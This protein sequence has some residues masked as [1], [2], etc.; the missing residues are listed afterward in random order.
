MQ[1]SFDEFE[2][3]GASTEV[4]QNTAKGRQQQGAKMYAKLHLHPKVYQERAS[5]ILIGKKEVFIS[6]FNTVKSQT[7]S[8]KSRLPLAYMCSPQRSSATSTNS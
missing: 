1:K 3:S 7:I 5:I 8:H 2:I 6:S 4:Y